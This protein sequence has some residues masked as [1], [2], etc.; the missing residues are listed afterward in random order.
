MIKNQLIYMLGDWHSGD[1]FNQSWAWEVYHSKEILLIIVSLLI[2]I[3]WPLDD[4]PNC[5]YT[6]F[7]PGLESSV[8]I[9][10]SQIFI[11]F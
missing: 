10:P 2:A 3:E 8:K 7:C 11:T 5:K 6:L 1:V 4:P 9:Q